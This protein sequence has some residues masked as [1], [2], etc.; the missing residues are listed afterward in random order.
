VLDLVDVGL[1]D[2]RARHAH[3]VDHAHLGRVAG[4]L[5]EGRHVLHHAAGAA[6]VAAAPDGREL[7]HAHEA[8]QHDVV[9]DVHV[10]GDEHAVDQDAVVAHHAVV[11]HVAAGHEHV[12][13]AD[14][15][16]RLFLGRATVDGH[17]LADD[18]VVAHLEAAL[19]G[20]VLQV[21]RRGADGGVCQ[22]VVARAQRG[23]AGHE[24]VRA[25]ARVRADLHAALDDR[26]R[27]DLDRVVQLRV[28]VDDRGG[29]DLAHAASSPASSAA[30]FRTRS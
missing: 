28:R 16:E 13:A 2:A 5:H 25:D 27:A 24:A 22:E 6:D 12:V 21:L 10:P 30:S 7:V 23:A 18:V 26:V 3:L 9:A 29:M 14:A 1:R 20:A 4:R 8:R 11:A 19:H 15:R 17:E